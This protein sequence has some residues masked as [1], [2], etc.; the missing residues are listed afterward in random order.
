MTEAELAARANQRAHTERVHIFRVPGRLGVYTT[1]SKSNPS[2]RYSL[3]ARDG[4]EACSCKGYECRRACRHVEALRNRLARE[5]VRQAAQ[6]PVSGA[7]LY[8]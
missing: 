2:E 6:R 5:Q 4:V 7:F 1:K 3:V 8:A